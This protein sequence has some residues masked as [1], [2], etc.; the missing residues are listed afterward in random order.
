MEEKTIKDGKV[1]NKVGSNKTGTVKAGNKVAR[2]GN[3][4]SQTKGKR[5]TTI[6]QTKVASTNSSPKSLRAIAVAVA[7]GVTSNV[8]AAVAPKMAGQGDPP[9]QC[10]K[11]PRRPSPQK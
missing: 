3:N 9:K 7:N 10:R 2:A 8:T 6:K 11:Q 1:V 4:A 5:T